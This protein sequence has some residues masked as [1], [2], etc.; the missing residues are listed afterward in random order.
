MADLGRNPRPAKCTEGTKGAVA[1]GPK[2]TAL[3][4]HRR[5]PFPLASGL[6]IANHGDGTV[7][8]YQRWRPSPTTSQP[9]GGFP[10]LPPSVRGRARLTLMLRPLR[11]VSS[12]P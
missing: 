11:S 4:R 7:V 8:H 5:T 12:S 1:F 9:R 6:H 3:S 10:R 2:G